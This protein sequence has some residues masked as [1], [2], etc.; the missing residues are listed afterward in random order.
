MPWLDRSLDM[1]L[2]THYDLD[3]IG[4]L[5]DVLDRYAV[6][7]IVKTSNENDTIATDAFLSAVEHELATIHLAMAGDVFQLGASTTF[8]VLSPAGD[9]TQ[10]ESN[11]AS[12]VGLLRYDDIEVL[13]TGDAGTGIEEYL[14]RTH[15]TALASEVLK[16]GHH[17]SD[18]S[19]SAA[20]LAAVQPALAIVSA[21]RDNRYGHPH[22]EVVAR[23]G[24][25]GA[26]ILSTFEQG[27]IV[28][29]SDGE[30]VWVDK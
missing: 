9:P 4:G 18:T 8:T 3:H 13:L 7:T 30:R 29:K 6:E 22:D 20:F 19:S 28:L 2:A 17:G 26:D 11:S 25:V 15:G 5:V 23:V 10:W 14:V 12:I 16:L 24:A 21:G 1:V 27:T